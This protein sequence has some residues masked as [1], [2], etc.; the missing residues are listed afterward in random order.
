MNMSVFNPRTKTI[1]NDLYEKSNDD[2]NANCFG[3]SPFVAL[4][5][6][7]KRKFFALILIDKKS[8]PISKIGKAKNKV[9]KNK[10]IRRFYYFKRSYGIRH[11]FYLCLCVLEYCYF[12]VFV[13]LIL[14]VM[15]FV[16]QKVLIDSSQMYVIM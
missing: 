7:K 13:I 3:V 9:S 5:A 8:M 11:V 15:K 6:N 1:N 14:I 12:I 2:K 16:N 10:F 4:K